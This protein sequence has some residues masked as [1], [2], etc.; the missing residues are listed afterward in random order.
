LASRRE[1]PDALQL[2]LKKGSS[3]YFQ[4]VPLVMDIARNDEQRSVFQ[5]LMG[6]KAL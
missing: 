2:D 4:D 5:I 3:H 6:M 1:D